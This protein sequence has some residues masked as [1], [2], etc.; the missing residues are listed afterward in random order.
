MRLKFYF[1]NFYVNLYKFVLFTQEKKEESIELF[2]LILFYWRNMF[3]SNGAHLYQGLRLGRHPYCVN[4]WMPAWF[5]GPQLLDHA[6]GPTIILIA[7]N[8]PLAKINHPNLRGLGLN[9]T[10]E[11]LWMLEGTEGLNW[12]WSPCYV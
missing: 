3:R 12:H 2:Y 5:T 11:Y 8:F 7:L 10:F 6:L 4:W 1:L 9:H